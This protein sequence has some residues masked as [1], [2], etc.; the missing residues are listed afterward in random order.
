MVKKPEMPLAPVTIAVRPWIS[1]EK[2][3]RFLKMPLLWSG[4]ASDPMA[5]SVLGM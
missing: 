3:G 2:V 1:G 4:S 5:K